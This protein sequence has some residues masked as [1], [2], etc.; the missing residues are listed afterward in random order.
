MKYFLLTFF[1]II[2]LVSFSQDFI[3]QSVNIKQDGLTYKFYVL[4]ADEKG[5][6]NYNDKKYYYWFKTQKVMSTQ[7]GS[8]GSLLD[9]TFQSFYTNNQLSEQGE[10]EK[11]L[12]D[13]EWKKWDAGGTLIRIEK[14]KDGVLRGKQSDYDK[15][16]RLT[17]TTT[18]R[19]RITIIEKVDTIITIKGKHIKTVYSD[20]LGHTTAVKRTKN[21]LLH[22]QQETLN[23]EGK[24]D[25]V[26]Y[27][28]GEVCQKKEK[29]KE[30]K[31]ESSA[32]AKEKTPLMKR[33]FKKKKTDASTSSA[34]SSTS[35]TS[36]TNGAQKESSNAE[37]KEKKKLIKLKKKKDD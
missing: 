22:G 37:P 33:I 32:E 12:K 17:S 14:W 20:S 29:S 2:R 3:K 19:R 9:G 7:G 35:S 28:N 25:K 10:F 26:Q 6:R 1:A 34:T 16:G 27:K 13:G 15:K 8:S 21:G 4:D 18:I 5:V 24:L 31:N 11:G 30:A 36:S 23:S